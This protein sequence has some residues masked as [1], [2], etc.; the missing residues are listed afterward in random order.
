MGRREAAHLPPAAIPPAV[1][2]DRRARCRERDRG[3]QR[4]SSPLRATT[5]RR[6]PTT[7]SPAFG[8]RYR[9]LHVGDE[10]RVSAAGARWRQSQRTTTLDASRSGPSSTTSIG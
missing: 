3:D 5:A 8:E 4:G 9:T 7:H 6:G 2:T 1:A 10:L